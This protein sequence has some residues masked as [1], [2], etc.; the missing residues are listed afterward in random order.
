MPV[1]T[2]TKFF[3]KAHAFIK[4]RFRTQ[5]PNDGFILSG[6]ERK[7][8]SQN[9]DLINT[10]T[11]WLSKYQ[12]RIRKLLRDFSYLSDSQY[13]VIQFLPGIAMIELD[14]RLHE[15]FAIFFTQ[16]P[17][18]F[19]L[20]ATKYHY[21]L[22]REN[23]RIHDML[24]M[25]QIKLSGP[26]H[27]KHL[28]CV[29]ASDIT[30]CPHELLDLSRFNAWKLRYPVSFLK[31]LATLK[32]AYTNEDLISMWGGRLPEVT[33]V[34]LCTARDMSGFIIR[35]L[36]KKTDKV[37]VREGN[38]DYADR[39]TKLEFAGRSLWQAS[40]YTS[41]LD[42][43]HVYTV[44]NI[45]VEDV[46]PPHSWIGQVVHPKSGVGVTISPPGAFTDLHLGTNSCSSFNQYS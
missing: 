46:E 32:E 41:E 18:H 8:L 4:K 12:R 19:P 36:A 43:E 34:E 16:S 2:L 3:P 44:S 7:I 13:L 42:D 6:K 10:D 37:T 33:T 39:A 30:E 17:V 25:D 24:S 9:Q 29:G 26:D 20:T 15:E 22:S 21:L 31:G 38:M 1:Q 11:K 28:K 45:I 5:E 14:L 35:A 40:Q 27:S 23:I